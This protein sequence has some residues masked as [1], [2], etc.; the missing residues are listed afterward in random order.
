MSKDSVGIDMAHGWKV[1][2]KLMLLLLSK[3]GGLRNNYE[4]LQLDLYVLL[5]FFTM[6]LLSLVIIEYHRINGN[7][8]CLLL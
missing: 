8:L 2:P 1:K 5:P 6:H 4:T 3:I 7:D